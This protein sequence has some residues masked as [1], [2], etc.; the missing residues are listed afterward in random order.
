MSSKLQVIEVCPLPPPPS[1]MMYNKMLKHSIKLK[2][3]KTQY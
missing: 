3:V 2:N 1:N